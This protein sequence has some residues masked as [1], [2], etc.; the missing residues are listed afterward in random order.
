M[1]A[2]DVG[3]VVAL[4]AYTGQ[5]RWQKPL[6]LSGCGGEAHG[7]INWTRMAAKLATMYDRGVLVVFGVYL[8]G[9]HWAKF[10]AGHFADRWIAALRGGDGGTLW[11]RPVGFRVRPLII[12][13]TLHAEPWKLDLHTGEP[14]TQAHPIT[15]QPY[16]WQFARPGHHCGCP[17]ASPHCLF[18]RSFTLGYYDLVGDFGTI[19]FGGQR[20]GCWINAIPAAGL[21]LVPEASAGCRCSFPNACTIAFQPTRT[22]KAW[23]MYS[24]PAST[25]PVQRL[26]LNL[27]MSGDR[28]DSSGN[29]WLGYPRP[30]GNPPPG[31]P[32]PGGALVL[33]FDLQ[34]EFYPGGRFDRHNSTSRTQAET[35]ARSGAGS[36]ETTQFGNASLS[37]FMPSSVTRSSRNNSLLSL[38]NPL[39]CS[40]PASVTGM[41]LRSS[42]SR[43][44]SPL[45]CSSPASVI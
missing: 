29:L 3:R 35:P 24:A 44:V 5:M 11:S 32:Q 20:P 25:T 42:T 43:L 39:R 36:I 7:R 14:K 9:H 6:D 38:V 10:F 15:G 30:Y 40:N 23:G 41:I 22:N 19:H 21:V 17:S 2:I 4:D 33:R 12:G 37:F 26:A 16:R 31:Y 45:T 18:F 8:D 34:T 27:G 28:K 13:D 1:I